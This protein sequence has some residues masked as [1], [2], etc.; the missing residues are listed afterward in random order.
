MNS[1]EKQ[2]YPLA[3]DLREE[4]IY[5]LSLGKAPSIPCAHSQQIIKLT[6]R[7]EEDDIPWFFFQLPTCF[8]LSQAVL[9]PLYVRSADNGTASVYLNAKQLIFSPLK[10]RF[11]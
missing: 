5:L 6:S 4:N 2:Q 9:Q 8:S 11:N 1:E 7:R 10:L 3:E